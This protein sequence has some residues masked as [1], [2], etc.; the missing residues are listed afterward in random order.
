VTGVEAF[1]TLRSALPHVDAVVIATPPRSH[2][3]LAIQALAAG[4]HVLVEKPMTTTT[5]SA[6]RLIEEAANRGLTLMVGHTFEHNAAV[7]KLR[8]V[9]ESGQ[10]G[11]IYYIDTA[12]LNLGLYQADVNV[13]WDLAPHDISIINH[14]L[15]AA[16]TSVQAWGSR[17][18]RFRQEDVAYLRLSYEDRSVQAQVHV[19]WLDPCKVRRV[20]VVGSRRMAV[21]D[22]LADDER[23]RIYDK[24]VVAAEQGDVRNRPMSYRYGGISAPYIQLHEPLAVQDQH[25][26]ECVATGRRPYTDGED[27][28]AVVQVLEAASQSLHRG[29]SV[30]LAGGARRPGAVSPIPIR[31]PELSRRG[32]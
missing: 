6:H 7:W 29:G 30:R 15:S 3:R 8:E 22:D 21:Y 11:E 16:P 2:A 26:V 31:Q 1:A 23:L 25:F 9:I 32:A 4:K 13:V 18:A 27:G 14:L 12:R 10:L 5:S 17:H 19:S 20:T 24:G 28:L